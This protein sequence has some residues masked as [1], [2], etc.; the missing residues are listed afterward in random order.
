MYKC[1]HVQ[2]VMLHTH[3]AAALRKVHMCCDATSGA[4]CVA[5]DIAL[6]QSL[7]AVVQ[8]RA[9]LWPFQIL[10]HCTNL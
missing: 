9:Y 10:Q 6:N 8:L 7:V 1:A 5:N 4:T 3:A 2:L